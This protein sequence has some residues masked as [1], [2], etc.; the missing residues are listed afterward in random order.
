MAVKRGLA[1]AGYGR[2]IGS[3][4]PIFG[5]YAV[6]HLRAFQRAQGLTRS[7]VYNP[8][9][10]RALIPFFDALARRLYEQAS[11]RPATPIPSDGGIDAHGFLQLPESFEPTHETAGL[12]G[13]PAVDVFA[14]P[15]TCVRAP[16]AGRIRRQS[17]RD[18]RF[19]GSPGGAY[20]WSLYLQ[21]P[22]GRDYFLTHF[23]SIYVAVGDRVDKGSII[24]TV[25]DSAVSH[26]PGTSHIH[27]GLHR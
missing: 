24:G 23:G 8:A 20:G 27:M 13:Y 1:R 14:K 19:G 21:T 12:P 10:H 26:K 11:R 3:F 9:T 25:C 6:A 4:N 16:A 22:D 15:G 17:G 2:L 18:P 5:P 7:G